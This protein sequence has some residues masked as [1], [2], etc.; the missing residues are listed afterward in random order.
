[1]NPDDQN[2][3]PSHA[4]MEWRKMIADEELTCVKS[5]NTI[6]EGDTYYEFVT[7]LTLYGVAI[8]MDNPILSEK[9]YFKHVLEGKEGHIYHDKKK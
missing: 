9:E 7:E 8:D 5:G 4:I 1:M 6:N 2:D 3:L